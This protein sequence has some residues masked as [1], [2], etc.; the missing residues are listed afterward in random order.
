MEVVGHESH[1]QDGV[2]TIHVPS[3]LQSHFPFPSCK[4]C[5]HLRGTAA[6]DEVVAASTGV[7][8]GASLAAGGLGDDNTV[9]AGG[10]YCQDCQSSI[11]IT[12]EGEPR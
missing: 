11:Y 12:E 5:R 8:D 7:G 1:R 6:G 3:L 10:A 9:R 2:R 4:S